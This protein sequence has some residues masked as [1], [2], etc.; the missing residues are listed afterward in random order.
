M[1]FETVY[2]MKNYT[3]ACIVNIFSLVATLLAASETK[4]SLFS[5][6]WFLRVCPM[7]VIRKDV[8]AALVFAMCLLVVL[9]FL[10]ALSHHG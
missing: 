7:G 9:S 2:W 6:G 10:V 1:S 5:V 8:Q 3:R 4:P